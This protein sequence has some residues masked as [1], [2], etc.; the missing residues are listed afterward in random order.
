MQICQAVLGPTVSLS[1]DLWGRKPFMMV[2][3]A[4]GAIGAIVTATSHHAYVALL[5]EC[6]Y[7]GHTDSGCPAL[8]GLEK[9]PANFRNLL[10]SLPG[11]VITG[12]GFA[13]QGLYVATASET[14]PRNK[15]PM[16]QAIFNISSSL[17]GVMGLVAGG[18]YIKHNVLGAGWRMIYA[19]LAIV[20]KHWQ[21]LG[22]QAQGAHTLSFQTDLPASSSLSSTDRLKSDRTSLPCSATTDTRSWPSTP[23]ALSSRCARS[24][25][26]T[27]V[28]S[29]P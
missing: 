11:A 9:D 28:S 2:G 19:T 21:P 17:G 3:L 1:A 7:R 25:R 14:F 4:L 24:F 16:M 10:D 13:S 20:C 29:A 8:H 6:T 12:F 5:G 27:T 22:L 26:S 23:S 18:L 15:R